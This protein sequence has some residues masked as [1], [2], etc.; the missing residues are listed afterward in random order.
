MSW[1]R[2]HFSLKTSSGVALAL[3]TWVRP[4]S[5][6]SGFTFT[7]WQPYEKETPRE[8]LSLDATSMEPEE[9]FTHRDAFE[10]LPEAEVVNEIYN[11]TTLM[12]EVLVRMKD[13]SV[14]REVRE[15]C[16]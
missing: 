2:E 1:G 11:A 7:L 15:S 4:V 8:F 16:S 10:T 9:Y 5:E 12:Y 3:V 6:S 14:T 13:E